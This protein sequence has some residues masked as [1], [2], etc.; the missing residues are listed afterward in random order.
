MR[1]PRR[2][3]CIK[4]KHIGDVLLMTPTIRAIRQAWPPCRI[5]ALVRRGAEGVLEENPDLDAILTLDRGARF[6]GAWRALRA[7][8][9]F[10]PDLVLDRK[11]VV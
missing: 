5:A 9:R 11:S 10:A 4:L 6:S 3:L 7:V 2:V 1:P 8:R